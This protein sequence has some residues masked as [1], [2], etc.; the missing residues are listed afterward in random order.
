MTTPKLLFIA[1]LVLF[2]GI[3]VVPLSPFI[4]LYFI[5]DRILEHRERK[6][7]VARKKQN[8][9]ILTSVN[10]WTRQQ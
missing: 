8:T 7:G 10:K 6:Q 9:N 1:F 3:I 5:I 2:I 4:T